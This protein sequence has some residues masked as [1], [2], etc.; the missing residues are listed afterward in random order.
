HRVEEACAA[1]NVAPALVGDPLRIVAEEEIMRELRVGDFG[2]VLRPGDM[3]LAGMAEL[4]LRPFL[5]AIGASDEKHAALP[6]LNVK[7]G[8]AFT[9]RLRSQ[10]SSPRLA[11]QLTPSAIPAGVA[12]PSKISAWAIAA[13]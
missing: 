4:E 11:H 10:M 6:Y 8:C 1:V 12:P 2:D 3:R 13:A 7:H 5:L 9:T